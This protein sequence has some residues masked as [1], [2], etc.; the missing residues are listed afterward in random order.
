VSRRQTTLQGCDSD[1]KFSSLRPGVERSIIQPMQRALDIFNSLGE[2]HQ[3]AATNYQLALYY[4]KV[5]TYQRDEAKTRDRLSLAF[6]HFAAAHHYFFS[7]I[8][9]NE[10]TFVIISLD[11]SQLYTAVSG[12]EKALL[13]CLDTSDAFV[14][15][16]IEAARRRGDTTWFDNM[17]ALATRIE[18]NVL[19]LLLNLAKQPSNNKKYKDMYR[20]ALATKRDSVGIINE[21]KQESFDD[22]HNLLT[23]LKNI[24]K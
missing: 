18:D 4:S 17:R 5:W 14:P 24:S 16:G 8:E 19:D 21:V 13:F 9:S 2:N 12:I 22:I 1:E 3:F 11:V 6:K 10:P 15:K 7:H 23:G 20:F